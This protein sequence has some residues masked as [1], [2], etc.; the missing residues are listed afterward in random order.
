[1]SNNEECENEGTDSLLPIDLPLQKNKRRCWTCRQKMELAQR[2]LGLCKC[3]KCV[4]ELIGHVIN[5]YVINY[6]PIHDYQYHVQ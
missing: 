1:M 3:G 5:Y 2:E 6:F 4:Q